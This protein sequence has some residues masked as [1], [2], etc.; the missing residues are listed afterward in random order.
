M[1][2]RDHLERMRVHLESC[3]PMEGCG[4]LAGRAG[5]VEEVIPVTNAAGSP[6][7]FRMDPAEQLR[8]FDRMDAEGLD[9]IGIFHSHPAGPGKP[10]VTD[11]AEAAYST[12]YI[13]W[14]HEGGDWQVAGFWIDQG[15]ISEVKLYAAD[16]E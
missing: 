4:L 9:L 16:G 1:L 12:V 8:A 11:I 14:S 13:I 5:A 10:S 15:R 6:V 7:R 2:K 3:L